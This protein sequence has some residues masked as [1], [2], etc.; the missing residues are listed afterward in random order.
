MIKQGDLIVSCQ[1]LDDEPL[2]SSFIMGRMALAAKV[3]GADAIRA[4]SIKDI[5]EIQDNVNL[6]IIGI[7]KKEYSDSPIYIT[8]SMVEID[9]LV[10]AKVDIIALDATARIRPFGYTLEQFFKMIKMKYP[11]QKLMAD[12]S[13]IEEMITSQQLGFDYIAT[14]LFGYT[15]YSPTPAFANGAQNLAPVIHKCS[16]PV[17]AE[18]NINDPKLA[19]EA[20]DAG[21]FAVVVGSMITRPRKITAKFKEALKE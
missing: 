7:I 5:K 19:R 3:G 4:N 1:A 12:C 10:E 11:D 8:P 13:T 20:L 18:G 15:E 2:H 14:T 17:I 16:V 21:C 6:P 9:A